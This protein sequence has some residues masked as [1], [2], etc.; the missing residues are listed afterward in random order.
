MSGLS[1]NVKDTEKCEEV[2]LA[3]NNWF[4]RGVL[5]LDLHVIDTNKIGSKF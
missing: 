5:T 2:G 4:Y 1:G 3:Q